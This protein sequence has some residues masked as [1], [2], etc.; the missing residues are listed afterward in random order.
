MS[1]QSIDLKPDDL[2]DVQRVGGDVTVEGSDRAQVEARGDSLHV[3]IRPGVVELTSSGDLVLR[4]P[5]GARLSLGSV[6]GDVELENLTGPVEINL[7]GGDVNLRNLSGAVRL[8][9]MI[10]GET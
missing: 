7:V 1:T 6:G 3:E 2:L 5:G 10:G 8:A 4:V 9:G